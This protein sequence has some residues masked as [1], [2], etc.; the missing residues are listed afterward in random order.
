MSKKNALEA[1]GEKGLAVAPKK[2]DLLPSIEGASK[3][4]MARWAEVSTNFESLEAFKI[5]RIKMSGNGFV[6][7]EGQDPVTEIDCI[8][9][10]TKRMNAWY[11]TLR[12]VPSFR[13]IAIH[14]TV[15][16]LTQAS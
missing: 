12:T 3:E 11:L 7:I 2:A 10:Y 16:R 14:W 1:A 8:L 4:L 5:P 9:V 6:F 13:P 15:R